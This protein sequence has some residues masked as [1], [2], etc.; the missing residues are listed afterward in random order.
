MGSELRNQLSW[1][2][3]RHELFRECLRRYFYHYYGAWGGWRADAEPAI[4]RLYVLKQL[5]ARHLWAG[6]LVHDAVAGLLRPLRDGRRG[7]ATAAES[8]RERALAQVIDRMRAEFRGSRS[9]AY[10]KDPKRAPGL[11]EHHYAEPVDDEQWREL[12]ATVRRS[13]EGFIDGPWLREIE[14]IEPQAFL[15]LEDLD[16]F[17]IAGVPVYVKLDLAHR[18]PPDGARIVDWKTG[19]RSPQP[20]GL[21]LGVYALFAIERWGLPPEAV[22]IREVNLS[23]G[24]EAAAGVS[25]V[26][27][28]QTRVAIERSIE[29]MRARLIDPQ[30]NLARVEDFPAQVAERA[31]RSCAFREVCPEYAQAQT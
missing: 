12:A 18:V 20:G 26:L 5:K 17:E 1:S 19:R 11:L 23:S 13:I 30:A 31:C 27:L 22:E 16:T 3:S 24:E 25:A 6:G 10:L 9:G 15:A 14:G 28:D 4:R 29:A 8:L 2:H 21:Q 7:P